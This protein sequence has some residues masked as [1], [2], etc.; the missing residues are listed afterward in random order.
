[1]ILRVVFRNETPEEQRQKIKERE[2]GHRVTHRE[3]KREF[4][5]I[6]KEQNYEHVTKLSKE[7]GKSPGYNGE[8]KMLSC[9]GD[10]YYTTLLYHYLY[11]FYAL[12]YITLYYAF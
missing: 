7:Y 3:H 11:I 9:L 5:R 4:Q 12:H 10:D 1:M 2:K 6:W 8:I